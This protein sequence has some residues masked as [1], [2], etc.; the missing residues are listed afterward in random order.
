MNKQLLSCDWGTSSF[1]LRLVDIDTGTVLAASITED[2]IGQTY[3]SWQKAGLTEDKRMDWYL[4]VVQ[5]HILQIALQV[6]EIEAGC[7]VIISGMASSSIGMKELPYAVLPLAANGKDLVLQSW[8]SR[9]Q[10][11]HPLY[12]ISGARTADDVMRGEET[13][14]LGCMGIGSTVKQLFIFPGTHSKHVVVDNSTVTD[15]IT[16]M[17]GEL[18]SLLSTHS[19]LASGVAEPDLADDGKNVEAFEQGVKAAAGKNLLHTFFLVR[20]NQLLKGFSKAA[21]YHFLSGMLIGTELYGLKNTATA[22]VIFVG[23]EKLVDSY[24]KAMEILQIQATV[25]RVDAAAAI[26]TGHLAVYNSLYQ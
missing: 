23:E 18:F 12:I 14:L 17:T 5:R 7:P 10:F 25:H 11:P 19:I 3:A 1:R 26:I 16:Y 20:S 24:C 15:L 8:K 2:G 22:A 6:K 13:Q 21:N 9:E 4:A